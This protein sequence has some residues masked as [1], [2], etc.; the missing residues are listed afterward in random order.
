M[1]QANIR[2]L[3]QSYVRYFMNKGKI[4]LKYNQGILHRNHEGNQKWDMRAP[5]NNI[6]KLKWATGKTRDWWLYQLL[7]TDCMLKVS[8]TKE[9]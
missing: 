7:I 4:S 8:A 2:C 5:K 3:P 6:A 9:L 1:K